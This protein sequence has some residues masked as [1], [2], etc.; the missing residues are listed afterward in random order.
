M[1]ILLLGFKWLC[2]FV[3]KKKAILLSRFQFS[4]LTHTIF[5]GQILAAQIP[6]VVNHFVFEKKPAAL[7]EKVQFPLIVYDG[8]LLVQ[9]LGAVGHQRVV[10]AEDVVVR[11]IGL[12]EDLGAVLVT[13]SE[14]GDHLIPV[15]IFAGFEE[16]LLV[17]HRHHTVH[18]N[19]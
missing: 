14:F 6:L 16:V 4:F 11:A 10:F 9:T 8:H 19:C 18:G 1:A 15:V 13:A 5:R 12:R 3:I 2:Y 7:L 17:C